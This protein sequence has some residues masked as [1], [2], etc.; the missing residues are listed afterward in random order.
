MVPDQPINELPE[1]AAMVP[2]RNQHYTQAVVLDGDCIG[3]IAS[4]VEWAK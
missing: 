3:W 2:L 1:G 4:A